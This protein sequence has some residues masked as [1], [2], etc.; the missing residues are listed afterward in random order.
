MIPFI[1]IV[2]LETDGVRICCSVFDNKPCTFGVPASI[3]DVKRTGER[4]LYPGVCVVVG[5]DAEVGTRC[6]S[7]DGYV[8]FI[9][10]NF[11]ARF[12]ALNAPIVLVVPEIVPEIPLGRVR[13]SEDS[14]D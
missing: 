12:R 1:V 5:V 8:V 14:S 4:D 13:K 10:N 9:L 7:P 3:Q 11:P 6:G 2:P